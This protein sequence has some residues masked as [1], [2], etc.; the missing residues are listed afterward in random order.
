[1]TGVVGVVGKPIL[2]IQTTVGRLKQR[3]STDTEISLTQHSTLVGDRGAGGKIAM[4]GQITTQ[5]LR[6]ELLITITIISVLIAGF[7]CISIQRVLHGLED[8][9]EIFQAVHITR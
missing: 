4:L 2:S 1:M 3:P 6:P 5:T 7:I 8:V 9:V